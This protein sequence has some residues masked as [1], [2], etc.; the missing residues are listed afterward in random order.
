[1][2]YNSKNEPY[3][4]HTFILPFIWHG[5]KDS[6]NRFVKYFDDNEFWSCSD[7]KKASDINSNSMIST[8]ED[9]ILLY[10]EYQYFHPFAR[11]AIYGFGEG[12]VHNYEFLHN[13]VH[14]K[15]HYYIEKNGRTYDLL[16]NALRLKI[17]NTGV[18][19]FI[20]ETTNYGVDKDG[21]PQN[22]FEDVKNINDYGR[23][24]SLPM[25]SEPNLCADSIKVKIGD[26]E[27]EDKF[28]A[29][30]EEVSNLND[31]NSEKISL[32]HMCDFVKNILGYGGDYTFT[33]R[34]T[35]GD[36][37]F[38]VYPILDDRMY[39]ISSVKDSKAVD[40]CHEEDSQSIYEYVYVDH[41]DGCSCQNKKMRTELLNK[42]LYE[43]W[44]DYGTRYYITD[45]SFMLLGDDELPGYIVESFLTQYYQMACLVISQRASLMKFKR[46][47][48]NMASGLEK[49]G[50]R[51]KVSSINKIMDLQERFV[52]FE[53]QLYFDEVSSEQQ[54][55][56]MY[57]KL[58]D[59]SMIRKEMESLRNQLDAMYNV[60]DTSLG[61]GINRIMLV[62]TWLSG[63]LALA[64]LVISTM[65]IQGFKDM[66]VLNKI[67]N[68]HSVPD[69]CGTTVD[70]ADVGLIV[71]WCMI[72]SIL[73]I[74]IATAIILIRYR[75][76]R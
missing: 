57:D 13:E 19:L 17:Y 31:V 43:R 9:R 20:I 70:G 55:I 63:I 72:L 33:S 64:A 3:S 60:S 50:K 10:K 30:I 37:E 67:F 66:D 49:T 38:Y 11:R 29:H 48:T 62:F 51:V 61:F 23:R 35:I 34:E 47:V 69:Y 74:I 32:T 53:S 12:I 58:V 75:R 68:T 24:I 25:I 22:T 76:K 28:R 16:I 6:Y 71:M 73:G 41:A 56:E 21:K 36:K 5:K 45:Y 15:A 8:K 44:T 65:Q 52:A 40:Q 2:G 59:Q 27:F 4:Y 1:M 26:I 18:A 46:E 14:E 7:M 39:V 42:A 54:G